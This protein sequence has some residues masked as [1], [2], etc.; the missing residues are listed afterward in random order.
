MTRS[1]SRLSSLRLACCS[2]IAFFVIEAAGGR[3][4]LG[5]SELIFPR[6]HFDKSRYTGFAIAN[7][8][9]GDAQV[10]LTAY[11]LDGRLLQGNGVINPVTLTVGAGKQ[12]S[13]ID[14]NIFKGYESNPDFRGW[15]LAQ[16][17]GSGLTGFFLM[18]DGAGK[19]LDG[20]SLPDKALD[21]YFN[22]LLDPARYSP[23]ISLVNPNPVAA[24]VSLTLVNKEG[25]VITRR[26]VSIVPSGA[27][28]DRLEN[29]FAAAEVAQAATLQVDSKAPVA[30]FEFVFA[31]DGT[32]MMGMN[33]QPFGRK[34]ST[35]N[36][37]QLAVLGDWFTQVGVFNVGSQLALVTITAYKPDGTLYAAPDLRGS[38]PYRV[39]IASRGA[40]AADVENLFGFQGDS[41]KSGWLKVETSQQAIHGFV[42]YGTRSNSTLAAVTAQSDP[43]GTTSAIFSHQANGGGFYTGLAILNASS[44]AATVEVISVTPAGQVLGAVKRV[45]GPLE[46]ISTL[47]SQLI[48]QAEG[49]GGGMIVVRSDQPVFTS[50][51]FGTSN[52]SSLANVPSQEAPTG[53]DPLPSSP[54]FGVNPPLAPVQLR[55][56]QSFQARLNNA[57]TGD[58]R[59]SVNGK[60]GGDSEVGLI[61][62]RGVY[63]AP[64]RL[65]L[66]ARVTVRAETPDGTQVAGATVDLVQKEAF[67]SDVN[68]LR[69]QTYLSGLKKLYVAELS[70]LSAKTGDG[71]PD[72]A[73]GS[74]VDTVLSEIDPAGQKKS[75][76]TFKGL[77]VQSVLPYVD[78]K[79]SE[80]LLVAAYDSSR[81]E[82]RTGKVIRYNPVSGQSLGV[83][84]E[85]KQPVAM[86]L[87]PVSSELLIADQGTDAVVAVARSQLDP[88]AARTKMAAASPQPRFL[89]SVNDPSGLVVDRCDGAV[90]TTESPRGVILR[91]DR[92]T[93]QTTVLVSRLQ[94]PGRLFGIFRHGLDCPDAFF[95]LVGEEPNPATAKNGKLTLVV[96]YLKNPLTNEA[97]AF[98]VAEELEHIPD[99]SIIPAQNPYVRGGQEAI[100]FGEE[101]ADAKDQIFFI[102]DEDDNYDE[103]VPDKEKSS[104]DAFSAFGFVLQDSAGLGDITVQIADSRTARVLSSV[105][106]DIFGVYE[107]P[108]VRPGTYTITPTATTHRFAPASRT[109]TIEDDDVLVDSF[110]ANPIGGSSISGKVVDA[111]GRSIVGAAI[112]IVDANE[113]A[114]LVFTGADGAY[115][116]RGLPNGNYAA[117][118]LFVGLE[119]NPE[120]RIVQINNAGQT[121]DFVSTG[122]VWTVGGKVTPRDTAS[123]AGAVAVL[124]D[125]DS[126]W[127]YFA[128]VDAGGNYRFASIPES[129]AP[130]YLVAILRNGFEFSDPRD[131]TLQFYLF[132]LTADL[133][134]PFDSRFVGFD[135]GGKVIDFKNAPLAG[136]RIQ[137]GN[138]SVTSG[139]D[140]LF[141]LS[142][143]KTNVRV[144]PSK[145]GF[146]FTPAAFD[147]DLNKLPDSNKFFFVGAPLPPVI[148]SIT[149]SASPGVP[150]TIRGANLAGNLSQIQVKFGSLVAPLISATQDAIRLWVPLGV[151]AG[152]TDVVLTVS[153]LSSLPFRYTVLKPAPIITSVDPRN[154]ADNQ[155][156]N[157]TVRGENFVGGDPRIG[158]S[159]MSG[160]E[161]VDGSVISATEVRATY[162]VGA[163]LGPSFR[164]VNMF[165]DG[166]TGNTYTVAVNPAGGT[167][168]VVSSVT[169]STAKPGTRVTFTLAGS[170][171]SGGAASLRLANSDGLQFVSGA[172]VSDGSITATY[173]VAPD[174][175]LGKRHFQVLVATR[176]SNAADFL[177]T[178]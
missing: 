54:R 115:L 80:Y 173:D 145:P 165:F 28:Q 17:P 58:V 7:P 140:G 101:L 166:V 121:A 90:Y 41:I 102:A 48:P 66:Q 94:K 8:G 110:E 77:S 118:P 139:A 127:L 79:G 169:P 76:T 25:T 88:T 13:D 152:T 162:R 150:I 171:F 97:A 157:F 103:D 70:A 141:T 61:D 53:Y 27:L 167:N 104:F 16:S 12:F 59:W 84:S 20:A 9:A 2:L 14:A 132:S 168:P 44:L 67:N 156:V 52:S 11:G 133:Q 126:D 135:I 105:K 18:G 125:S 106:T 39:A 170:G 72:N 32:D 161:L 23:E 38:N 137:Y 154:F 55:S 153:G 98:T 116:K 149:P 128:L 124:Y 26:D 74:K 138:A 81:P 175:V 114:S 73:A 87:D 158:I 46:R 64:A 10:T 119:F 85:L 113:N 120:F 177:V 92:K 42:A 78:S 155:T 86:A 129:S 1:V 31:R 43:Q 122:R 147:I 6:I 82:E 146:T 69:S 164:G 99:I 4:C 148:Q 34:F 19:V 30:G 95:L 22:L 151:P 68:F 63:A 134:L 57:T 100:V 5:A 56:R 112:Y 160:F 33:A 51:L 35:L 130:R 83:I 172:V 159:P 3:V 178:P 117:V 36:F 47:V 96:P 131:P 65:P 144:S 123:P 91:F 50:E 24:Q 111:R 163:G 75:V 143:V 107:L 93:K 29:L 136:V 109:V 60:A 108:D 89:F 45:L 15:V 142:K 176:V 62:S 40:F 21:C 71:F 37:P 174:L 49:Q